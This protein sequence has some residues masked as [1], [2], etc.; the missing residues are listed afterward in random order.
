MDEC[1]PKKKKKEAFVMMMT[2]IDVML[3]ACALAK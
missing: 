3:W 2:M 1:S